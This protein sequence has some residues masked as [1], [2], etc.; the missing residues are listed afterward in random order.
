MIM[1]NL[2]VYIEDRSLSAPQIE[3]K[4]YIAYL[5]TDETFDIYGNILSAAD[6]GGTD[7]SEQINIDTNLDP[8]TPGMYEI[9]Y[10]VTD[11]LGRTGHKFVIVIVE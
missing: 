5:K 9:H 2:P 11:S 3:L 4:E 1:H 10:R 8:S 7:L 6:A